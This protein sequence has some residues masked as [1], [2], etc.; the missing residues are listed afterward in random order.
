M[1]DYI[2]LNHCPRCG[3]SDP[4]PVDR[5]GWEYRCSACGITYVP[6][7]PVAKLTLWARIRAMIWRIVR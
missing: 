4:E 3:T 7:R 5:E 2:D 6:G 1:G